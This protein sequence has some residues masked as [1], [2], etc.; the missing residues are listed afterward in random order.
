MIPALSAGHGTWA[1]GGSGPVGRLQ[2]HPWDTRDR[3]P[4]RGH[5]ATPRGSRVLALPPRTQP[6]R[7][8]QTSVTV[9]QPEPTGRALLQPRPVQS[10]HPL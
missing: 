6:T 9:L 3:S 7:G 4:R 10:A 5:P 1:A 8:V 2:Q